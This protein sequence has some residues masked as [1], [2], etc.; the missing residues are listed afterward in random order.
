MT[1]GEVGL[2]EFARAAELLLFHRLYD[3]ALRLL[4]RGCALS[5]APQKDKQRA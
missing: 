3:D 4:R 1:V 5:D 2:P